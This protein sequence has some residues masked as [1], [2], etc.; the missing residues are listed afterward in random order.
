[1]PNHF[2]LDKIDGNIFANL[3]WTRLPNQI[4]AWKNM[5]LDANGE[6]YKK[7]V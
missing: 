2:F 5:K 1:M 7:K 6:W 4:N 3:G